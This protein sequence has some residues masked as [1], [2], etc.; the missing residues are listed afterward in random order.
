MIAWYAGA[1]CAHPAHARPPQSIIE[2]LYK[3]SELVAYI[4]VEYSKCTA[5]KFGDRLE[6]KKIHISAD[7]KAKTDAIL[8]EPV[9]K[10]RQ[11]FS[12]IFEVRKGKYD[13]IFLPDTSMSGITVLPAS[14]DGYRLVQA[15]VHATN[16]DWEE[17]DFAYD[18]H[19][20][21]YLAAKTACFTSVDDKPIARPCGGSAVEATEK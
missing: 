15:Y 12:A 11:Y 5:S 3:D 18:R 7:P 19:K 16:A 10:N 9:K 13:P 8:V 6:A 1:A 4:C 20:K 2:Y 21:Q 17:I 14:R